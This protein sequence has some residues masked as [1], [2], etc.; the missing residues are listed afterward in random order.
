MPCVT[1]AIWTLALAPA[2]PIVSQ[3]SLFADFAFHTFCASQVLEIS[4][5]THF[6]FRTFRVFHISHSA[7]FAH[8][9]HFA[10]CTF[11]FRTFHTSHF[12]HFSHFFRICT[13][14][15]LSHPSPLLCQPH[16]HPHLHPCS[17]CHTAAACHYSFACATLHYPSSHHCY[18]RSCITAALHAT[19]HFTH[20]SAASSHLPQPSPLSPRL[21]TMMVASL[22]NGTHL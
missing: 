8:F 19:S 9:A 3:I 2:V 7:H 22:A 14:V 10:H 21:S 11:V 18:L 1:S 15:W 6:A 5:F 12:L 20:M 13:I 16:F 4:C 17:I